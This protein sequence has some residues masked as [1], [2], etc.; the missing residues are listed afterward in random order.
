MEELVLA[1]DDEQETGMT[2]V[3]AGLAIAAAI[4]IQESLR[5]EDMELYPAYAHDIRYRGFAVISTQCHWIGVL[6]D[7]EADATSAR[8][9]T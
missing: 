8:R 5:I 3:V 2:A 6:L 4:R 1:A 9:S 7:D